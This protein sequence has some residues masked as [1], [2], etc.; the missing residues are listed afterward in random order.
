MSAADRP[1]H[2]AS[3]IRSSTELNSRSSDR[4][5]TGSRSAC[6]TSARAG[7][8][9][10][11]SLRRGRGG[12]PEEVKNTTVGREPEDEGGG[13]GARHTYSLQGKKRQHTRGQRARHPS[14]G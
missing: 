6:Q 7:S 10:A 12:E 14:R 9:L 3:W 13:G 11:G 2:R 1:S 5:P 4:A 8:R